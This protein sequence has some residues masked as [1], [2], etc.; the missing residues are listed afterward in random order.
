MSHSIHI[1]VT[2]TLTELRI[3]VQSGANTMEFGV[4]NQLSGDDDFELMILNTCSYLLCSRP[5][6]LVV[7]FGLSS[8]AIPKFKFKMLLCT[9]TMRVDENVP[10]D[11]YA[12]IVMWCCELFRVLNFEEYKAML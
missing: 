12:L 4:D 11:V 10:S 2:P 9:W 5:A 7:L 3:N 8:R 6:N 1:R